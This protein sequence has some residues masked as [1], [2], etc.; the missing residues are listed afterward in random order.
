[1][2]IIINGAPKSATLFVSELMRINLG[3]E[4]YRIATRGA[5]KSWIM[6][7]EYYQF[8]KSSKYVAQ[9]HIC[10]D[11][12]N[13]IFLK[14]FPPSIFIHLVRDP[15]DTLVSWK[16]HISRSD[17]HS[18]EDTLYIAENSIS[19]DFYNMSD[20]EKFSSLL[21]LY[22][23]KL[24]DWMNKWIKQIHYLGEQFHLVK[25]TPE[26]LNTVKTWEVL[27]NR[28]NLIGTKPFEMIDYKKSKHF[29]SGKTKQY[30]DY[31]TQNQIKKMLLIQ[32]SYTELSN[33]LD[34]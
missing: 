22:F 31:F 26:I 8:I 7:N 30:E 5:L 27:L 10:P 19:S 16:H 24:C 15:K 29:R 4:D 9:Q 28:Y 21:D 17:L 25:S 3:K 11:N 2:S 23:P 6:P 20:E 12:F 14:K 13:F 34:A 18:W 32:S 1:M 33:F